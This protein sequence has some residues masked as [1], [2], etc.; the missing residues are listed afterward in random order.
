MRDVQ[1]LLAASLV[2]LACACDRDAPAPPAAPAPQRSDLEGQLAQLTAKTTELERRI[3]TAEA[4]SSALRDDLARTQ[5]TLEAAESRLAV[6]DY[7]GVVAQ[8]SA[9]NRSIADLEAAFAVPPG[10]VTLETKL[11]FGGRHGLDLDQPYDLGA[12][13]SFV[14]DEVR[15]WL[16]NV[17]LTMASGT[18]FS[19]PNAYY[20]VEIM[21]EQKLANG[22]AGVHVLPANRR[23]S[24][25]LGSVPAGAY[26]AIEFLVGVDAPHNDNLSLGGG[27]LHVLKNM[28]SD[29]GWMWLTSYVFSKVRGRVVEGGQSPVVV[30]WE[31]G[32]NA[33]LRAVR[34]TFSAPVIIDAGAGARISLELDVK[35]LFAGIDPKTTPSIRA[36]QE[37]ERAALATSWSNAF[38]L[39]SA[40]SP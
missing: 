33:D 9:A 20:L 12:G 25:A 23:E 15:F 7:A 18:V 38:E 10:G 1:C 36:T 27:E 16:T 19:V 6:E 34:K 14:F 39:V 35:K 21:K 8:L 30:R 11:A 37:S 17:K 28:T 24:I 32:T 5:A 22:A 3:E 40:T 2:A 29:N 4:A 31:T 13:R 26:T